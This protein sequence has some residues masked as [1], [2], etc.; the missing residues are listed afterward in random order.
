MDKMI[1]QKIVISTDKHPKIKGVYKA[2]W[3]IEEL[4]IIGFWFD[5]ETNR[6]VEITPFGKKK[7]SE[8]LKVW[9]RVTTNAL[10]KLIEMFPENGLKPSNNSVVDKISCVWDLVKSS[11][12]NPNS[13]EEKK[14]KKLFMIGEDEF[15]K[16]IHMVERL[17]MRGHP[18]L[19]SMLYYYKSQMIKNPN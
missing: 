13:S 15:I 17:T 12:K 9:D 2:E 7:Y 8:P 11:T 10:N 4:K 16:R 19:E 5:R 3:Y 6:V 18:K 14:E 1:E